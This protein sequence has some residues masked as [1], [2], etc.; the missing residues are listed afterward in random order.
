MRCSA[1][2]GLQCPNS[3]YEG[4]TKQEKLTIRIIGIDPGSRIT[5]YGIIDSDGRRSRHVASG[6]LA[7]TGENLAARLH[8][9]FREVNALIH[10]HQPDEVAIEEVFMARNA[11]SALKLGH[12]RGAAICASVNYGLSIAEYSAR[13]IKQ[14]IVGRG[15]AEKT[16]V[17]HMVRHLLA[18]TENPRADAADAL[19]VALCHAHTSTMVARLPRGK[20]A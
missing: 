11:A 18:L 16:Q 19:A 12:A 8:I 7:I 15:G 17:Q 9:I 13:K 6:C 4:E 3:F 20:F 5:G 1:R 14:A 2:R 10:A